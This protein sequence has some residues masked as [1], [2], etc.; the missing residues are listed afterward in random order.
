MRLSQFNQL[1]QDEFGAAYAQ[2]L[3]RDSVLTELGDR[4]GSQALVAGTDPRE[5]WLAICRLAGV[6]KTRWHGVDKKKPS[7]HKDE[8]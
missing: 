7:E 1:M 8:K 4:T 6:P 5:V 2:V 3:V